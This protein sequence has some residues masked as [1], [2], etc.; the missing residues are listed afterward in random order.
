MTD[1]NLWRL[2]FFLSLMAF[3]QVEYSK[4]HRKIPSELRFVFVLAIPIRTTSYK[5]LPWTEHELVG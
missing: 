3:F 1:L 5:L 4:S 2:R